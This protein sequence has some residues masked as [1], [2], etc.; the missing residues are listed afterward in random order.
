MAVLGPVRAWYASAPAELGG[1]RQR[2]VLARLV[3]AQGHVVSVDR[4]ID[5]LWLGEP[6]PKALSALQAYISHLRRVLEPDREPRTPAAVIVSEA[7]G[8]RLRLPKAAV[9]AWRFDDQVRAAQAQADPERRSALLTAAL[10]SWTGEPYAEIRDAQWVL[11]EADRLTELR[12]TAMESRA[13]AYL[14]LGRDSAA[15]A[16]LEGHVREHP[17]REAAAVVLATALYRTGRQAAALDVLR[18]TRTHLA[19]ELG[20]EPGR[21]VR[22]LEH[23]ILDHA[24]RLV[25]EVAQRPLVRAT[26]SAAPHGRSRELGMLD[27]AAAEVLQAGCRLVWLSGEAGAGKTTLASAAVTRLRAAG[28]TV[29]AGRCPEVDGAPPGWAWTEVLRQFGEAYVEAGSGY[30]G[31]LAALLHHH[32]SD[33]GGGHSPFWTA[34]AVAEV[35]TRAAEAGPVV[36]LLD[37]LHRTDGLTL[38]LLRLVIHELRDRPV[39]LVATYRP[40]ES[41]SELNSARAAL[42]VH[43]AAHLSIGGLDDTA[44]AALAADCGLTN[45]TAEALRL[46]HDRTGGNPLFV[47]ELARLSVA[48]GFDAARVAVPA[49]VGDVLRRRL[50]QL[51]GPTVTALRQAAVLGRE[52]DVDALADLAHRAPDD[53]L[54]A[55]EPA[56]LVGLLDEPGPGRIRFAHALVRDTLY[57]DTSLLRRSRLHAT[58]LDLLRTSGRDADP[59]ALAYHA[60]A[61]ATPASAA[62]AADLAMAAARDAD[63]LGAPIEAARQWRSAV[64][65]LALAGRAETD[66]D[67]VGRIIAAHCGLVSAAARVGD[68][69]GARDG[70]TQALPLAADSEDGAVRLL[71]AWD[72]PLIW[73]IRVDDT[74]DDMIV[75]SLRRVLAGP[76]P[77]AQRVRLLALLFA[78]LEGFDHPA[79]L[80]ASAE[81]LKLAR[82]L[83]DQDP[84]AHG[85]TLCAAL[86]VAAYAA[87]GP[88]ETHNRD[89]LT[90]EFLAAADAAAAVDYQAVAHWLAFLSAAGVSDLVAAQRH[91][92]LSVA[93]AG[94]GQLAQLLTVLEVFTA[95]LTVLAGRIDDGERRYDRAAAQFAEQGVANGAMISLVGRLTAGLARGN[96]AALADELTAVGAHVSTSIADAAVLALLDAGR[97]EEAHRV[98]AGRKPVE[99]SYYWLAITTLRAHAAARVN[100]LE[101]AAQCAAELRPYSGRMAGLDNGSLLTGPVDEALA[102]VAEVLGDTDAACRYRAAATALRSRLE[103]EANTALSSAR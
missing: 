9:D 7:P 79:A 86:N 4:L 103:S 68:I 94:T 19:D 69:V 13:E 49:G 31:A 43:T 12:F 74:P 67:R 50:E 101:A 18:R 95:G 27:E 42:A 17:T 40:S 82:A 80:A 25:G 62:E 54:D 53:L 8:Y 2:T 23:D 83:Y 3:L 59:A 87:L 96:I 51:P 97:T 89:Q 60:V 44:T 88:D 45:L 55:L 92:D 32:D 61:A 47:R 34:H 64:R 58:A 5:D 10:D 99:R 85:R 29:A 78:E 56:I 57:E 70:L 73:R 91:V 6:P 66:V 33:K 22:D 77:P 98:W 75:G 76:T 24:P 14:A 38:E 84:A 26:E 21:A 28:W 65:M 48:D 16:E 20:L 39:L 41:G 30:A 35:M 36:V 63:R 11:A 81:A 100:D 52:V 102:A 72:A 46:L 15:A 90:A 93:R 71:S 1:P 37:D